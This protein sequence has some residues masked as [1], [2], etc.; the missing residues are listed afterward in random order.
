M[1]NSFR[2]AGFSEVMHEV[3]EYPAEAS[4]RYTAIA[5][6]SPHRGFT[7]CR[8]TSLSPASPPAR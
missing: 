8:W 4:Y 7:R 2:T 6:A 5:Y 3:K 1:R